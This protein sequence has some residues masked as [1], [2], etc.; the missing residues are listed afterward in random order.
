MLILPP[1]LRKQQALKMR[2]EHYGP[3]ASTLRVK[4]YYH[5]TNEDGTPGRSN[6]CTMSH[7][8]YFQWLKDAPA[9]GLVLE[10]VEQIRN[11]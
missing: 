2:T 8:G 11:D 3:K 7:E 9:K 6:W 1:H 5:P 10:S 4:V